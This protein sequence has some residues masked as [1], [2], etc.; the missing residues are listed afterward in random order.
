MYVRG[1]H[2]RICTCCTY[3]R[4]RTV[5]NT[6]LCV[7]R[8]RRRGYIHAKR[9]HNEDVDVDVDVGDGEM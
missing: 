7:R 6:R 5:Y 2:V 9:S 1:V 4:V 3:E 8:P